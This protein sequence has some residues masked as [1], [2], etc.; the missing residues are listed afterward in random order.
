MKQYIVDAFTEKVF[1]GNPA[2]VCYPDR[3]PEDALMCRIAAENNLSETAFV[4]WEGD[5]L[6]IRWFTPGG[7]IDLCGHATLASAYVYF[8]FLDPTA[9]RVTFQSL[10]GPLTVT[11][12]GDLLAM[13]FP[14]YEL[15]PTEV[16]EDMAAVLGVRP[17][18]A[19]LG[20]DLLC[21]LDRPEDVNALKPDLVK[22]LDLPGLLLHATAPGTG[23]ADCVSRTFA[24]KL[25]V[26]EDPVC[27]SGHCHIVPYWANR[28]GKD[29]LTAYQAS[30]RGGTLYCRLAGDRVVLAGRAALFSQGEILADP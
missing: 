21:V 1:A 28:L 19:W 24:P 15:S 22:A 29:K 25:R 10:S 11:L 17:R 30:P 16:T 8:R 4:V 5:S 27:G 6:R 3:W 14:A 2:A 20:R 18:E 26:D 9:E 12:E 23:E 7:E 13:D